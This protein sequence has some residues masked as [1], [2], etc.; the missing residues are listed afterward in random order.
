MRYVSREYE[1][2]KLLILSASV[3]FC[4]SR[5]NIVETIEGVDPRIGYKALRSAIYATVIHLWND[6]SRGYPLV[7]EDLKVRKY[8]TMAMVKLKLPD[9]DALQ[10]II[11][12]WDDKKKQYKFAPPKMIEIM[13]EVSH[14][15]FNAALLWKASKEVD[16]AKEGTGTMVCVVI[17][18]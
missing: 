14:T 5:K 11:Y 2:E 4:L 10:E 9:I 17:T 8:D 18:T 15:V 16:D 3:A 13:L 6:F 1:S 12:K 7:I